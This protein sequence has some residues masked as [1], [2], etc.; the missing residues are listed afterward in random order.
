MFNVKKHI[1]AVQGQ[2]RVIKVIDFGTNRKRVC[3]LLLVLNSNL[4]AILHRFGDMVAYRSKNHKFV[5]TPV[6]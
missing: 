1:M 5:P 6:S 2:F 4:G 3:D